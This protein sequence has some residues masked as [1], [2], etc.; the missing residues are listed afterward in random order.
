MRMDLVRAAIAANMMFC[1]PDPVVTEFLRKD[2]VVYCVIE[3][4]RSRH[5]VWRG[6]TSGHD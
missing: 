2:R 6:V 3:K 4:A 1:S 5:L